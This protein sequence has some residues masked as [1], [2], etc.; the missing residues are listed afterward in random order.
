MQSVMK[1][2][3]CCP[4]TLEGHFPEGSARLSMEL[5]K[6]WILA[7]SVWLLFCRVPDAILEA[8]LDTEHVSHL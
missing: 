5:V 8:L 1:I 6:D 2:H 4:W 7:H 3:C